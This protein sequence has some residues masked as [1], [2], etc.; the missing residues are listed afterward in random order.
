MPVPKSK[1]KAIRF[2]IQSETPLAPGSG[3]RA[4]LLNVAQELQ[5]L[6]A[7][8]M[9]QSGVT[10]KEQHEAF[11]RSIAS[12]KIKGRPAKLLL[13]RSHAVADLLSYWQKNERYLDKLAVP[14]V[15]PIR[16]RGA[17]LES[18]ARQFVPDMPVHEVVTAI[19]RHGEVAR[20]MGDKVALVGTI[21][22]VTPKTP[23]LTLA[24]ITLS[25][26]RLVR[27][28]LHNASLPERKKGRGR[29]QRFAMGEL[30]AQEFVEW[31]HRVRPDLQKYTMGTEASLR[32]ADSKRRKGK[33]S[34][35]GIFVFRD[36]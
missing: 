35:V 17:T 9:T 14:R 36:E 33:S 15:L 20:L 11:R 30:T 10:K 16:G 8:A 28:I 27:T 18:L 32:L 6:I 19:V 25:A 34:G 26:Q 1:R 24:A 5:H 7:E 3:N 13:E 31:L 12:T 29:F 2:R 22:L 21:M 4:D 23:E